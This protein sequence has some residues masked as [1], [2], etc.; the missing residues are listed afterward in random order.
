MNDFNI[1]SNENI[2]SENTSGV[3]P[4]NPSHNNG[5][6]DLASDAIG[7]ANMA[8]SDIHQQ[9]EILEIEIPSHDE[10]NDLLENNGNMELASQATGSKKN[11][12]TEKFDDDDEDLEFTYTSEAD[13][14]P[15][16]V[17]DGYVIKLNDALTDSLPF[18]LNVIL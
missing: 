6:M 12:V 8:D 2:E 16:Q 11:T 15:H 17:N 5:N 14:L 1:E 4:N 9:N 13:F 10:Q 3:E 18:K 7:L